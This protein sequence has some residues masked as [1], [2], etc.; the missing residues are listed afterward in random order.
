[1]NAET[2]KRRWF[3]RPTFFGV[4]IVMG[5]VLLIGFAI[6][7]PTIRNV[8]GKAHR[9]EAQMN[10]VQIEKAYDFYQSG[11]QPRLAV[12][13]PGYTA[14][15]FVLSFARLTHQNDAALWFIKSDPQLAGREIPKNIILGDLTNGSANPAFMQL[16][17]SYEI[18]ANI[19][20]A[21]VPTT[22]PIAW[23]RGLQSDGTWLPDSPWQGEGG[24]IA[25][26]DGHV[27]WIEKFSS[28]KYGTN[29]PTTNIR[30][31]LPPGAVILSAEPKSAAK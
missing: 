23:T 26:L 12:M 7:I 5:G 31:A 4:M 16:P 1:M 6:A 21:S 15:D 30:E 19:P 20:H 8:I 14:Q 25:Y 2:Q 24:H 28:V 13:Q 9:Y 11:P 22:T 29:I 10:L 3:T 17:L 27:E 18:L